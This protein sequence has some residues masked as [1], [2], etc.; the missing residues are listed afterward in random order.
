V[1]SG[2]WKG[3]GKGRT[4]YFNPLFA[5]TRWHSATYWLT[6]GVGVARG[7]KQMSL[8]GVWGQ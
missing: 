1:L 2:S 6:L 4:V 8:R 7:I 5:K 3:A